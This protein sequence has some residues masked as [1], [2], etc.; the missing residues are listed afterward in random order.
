MSSLLTSSLQ[1]VFVILY[2]FVFVFMFVLVFVSVFVSV[3]AFVSK[4]RRGYQAATGALLTVT[5]SLHCARRMKAHLLGNNPILLTIFPNFPH[6]F[7]QSSSLL[8][9][10]KLLLTVALLVSYRANIVSYHGLP[11]R[12]KCM[13]PAV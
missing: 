12:Q 7:F 11:T 4:W 3:A 8:E 9:I 6:N 10:Y 2:V 5:S 13:D 1:A